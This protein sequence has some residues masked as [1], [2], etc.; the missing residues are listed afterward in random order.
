MFVIFLTQILLLVVFILKKELLN[1]EV[2]AIYI[3]NFKLNSY[4]FKLS[5]NV[6][7]LFLILYYLATNLVIVL[8]VE[9]YCF[10]KS[11][12]YSTEQCLNHLNYFTLIYFILFQG[13]RFM[14]LVL[15]IVLI[16]ILLVTR[17]CNSFYRVG[18]FF[19][20]T[21]SF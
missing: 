11:F 5:Q 21:L 19:L 9:K 14:T 20:S 15:F 7:Y 17:V 8:S 3:L 1:F 4:Q 12:P 16:I 18:Q 6:T 2:F 10:S 13:I